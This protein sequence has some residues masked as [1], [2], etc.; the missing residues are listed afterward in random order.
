MT[1]SILGCGWFGRALAGELLRKGV[2]VNG[3]T[4]SREKLPE[5]AALNIKPYLI[6]LSIPELAHD[7]DFFD[8][9]ILVVSIP[10]KVRKGDTGA[11]IPK[12]IQAILA[13]KQYRVPKVI[14]TSSTGVYDDL[15]GTVNELDAPT[16]TELSG[17]LLLEAEHLLM[18]QLQHA[19]TVIRFGGLVG[20]G[21]HPGRFFAGRKN[22]PN[23]LARVNLIHL[24]DAVGVT[25]GIMQKAA[26][27][28]VF[29]AC[30][31]GHPTKA[32]FYKAVSKQAGLELPEFINEK[33]SDKV[34]DSVN[35]GPLLHYTYK[36]DRLEDCIF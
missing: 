3:S 28:S 34:V 4:T 21:R 9:D 25:L 31:P 20:H 11:F 35:V 23:G 10:P 18:E 15:Q 24:D 12:I 17:Q 7:P 6:D 22:I 32:D 2:T 27:G 1:V 26:W 5:L 29:N 14:Y 19:V 30:S 36:Y 16:P 33:L 8:C 13:I